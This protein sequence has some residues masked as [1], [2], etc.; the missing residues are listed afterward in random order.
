MSAMGC[1][2]ELFPEIIDPALDDDQQPS[3]SAA[4]ALE[5]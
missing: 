3:C 2:P 1:S 4:E 5:R